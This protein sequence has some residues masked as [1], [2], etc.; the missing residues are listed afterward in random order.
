MQQIK[1]NTPEGKAAGLDN[2]NVRAYQTENTNGDK[3]TIRE[4]KAASY[5]DVDGKGDQK[6]HFNVEVNGVDTKQ[7][8]NWEKVD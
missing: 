6:P 4:D 8:H 1:P 7:H 3:V 2:R 5:G